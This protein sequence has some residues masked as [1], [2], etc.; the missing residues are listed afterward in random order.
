MGP[1][2][3][4]KAYVRFS[5]EDA[6]RLE[7]FWPHV[8]PRLKDITREFYDRILEFYADSHPT[9]KA[10]LDLCLLNGGEEAQWYVD[11]A[12]GYELFCFER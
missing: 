7:D 3:E 12:L 10:D 9:V 5:A 1:F 6:Q 4:M 2:D 11:G 8:E